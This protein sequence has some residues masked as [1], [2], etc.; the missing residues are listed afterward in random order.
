MQRERDGGEKVQHSQPSQEARGD[1]KVQERAPLQ[2]FSSRARLK[3][4]IFHEEHC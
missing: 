3:G 1:S 4:G 2:V